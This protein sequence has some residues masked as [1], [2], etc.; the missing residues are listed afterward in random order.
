MAANEDAIANLGLLRIRKRPR[1][2]QRQLDY[3]KLY[4]KL[5]QRHERVRKSFQALQTQNEDL[6]ADLLEKNREIEELNSDGQEICRPCENQGKSDRR[7]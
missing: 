1:K 2:I 7:S 5:V 6:T 4:S 3:E